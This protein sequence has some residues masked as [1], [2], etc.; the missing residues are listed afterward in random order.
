MKNVDRS[1]HIRS[2][3]CMELD[4]FIQLEAQETHPSK[5][6]KEKCHD[7]VHHVELLNGMSVNF[8]TMLMD[9]TESC[10]AVI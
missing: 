2:T 10:L 4:S 3:Q 1:N 7:S 9:G 6:G 5:Y 8:Q